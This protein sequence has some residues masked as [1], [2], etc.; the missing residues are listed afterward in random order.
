MGVLASIVAWLHIGAVVVAIGGA[1]FVL[2]VLRPLALRILE[3]PVAMQLVGAIQARFRWVV[4]GAIIVLIV[5]GLWTSIAFRGVSSV[6]ALFDTSFGRTLLVKSLLAL[7]LFA[8]VLAATL[9]LSWLAWFRQHQVGVMRFNLT[10]AAVV[11]LLATL[12]VRYGGVF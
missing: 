10:V 1:T 3:P 12:L 8:G 2:F 4:W 6:E 7:A 11:V 9:P 5:T